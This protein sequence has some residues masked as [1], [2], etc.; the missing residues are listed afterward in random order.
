MLPGQPSTF[1]TNQKKHRIKTRTVREA[2][3]FKL[4][5]CD[6]VVIRGSGAGVTSQGF[7]CHN[8]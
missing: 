7:L 8:F 5:L 3:Y 6:P 4:V 2:F 1:L